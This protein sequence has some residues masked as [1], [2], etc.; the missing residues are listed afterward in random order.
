MN[1]RPR[2]HRAGAYP[3]QK[4]AMLITLSL[5]FITLTGLAA[6]AFDLGHLL[7]VRNELQNAADAAALAGANCLNKTSNSAGTD[8]TS[9]PS[10]TL[11]WSTASLRANA[12][13]ALNQSD[14]TALVNATVTT[15]YKNLAGTPAG[16]Q[17][18]TPNPV[19]LYDKPAVMVS[20]SRSGGSN[21]GAPGMLLTAMFNVAPVPIS[22][23]AVAVISSPGRVA[24]NSLIPVVIN[25]CLFDQYWDSATNSPKLAKLAN[26][27]D[28][29]GV[30]Q[31]IG[32]PWELRIGSSYHYPNCESGQWTSFDDLNVNGEI[33]LTKLIKN[34]NPT[35]LAIGD[36]IWVMPGTMAR[37]YEDLQDRH[38]TPPG[39]NVT[40]I[41]VNRPNGLA[42]KGATSIVGFAG[43][44]ITAIEGR[45]GKYI[46]G[47]FIEGAVA[48]GSSGIGPYYGTYTPPRL[49][50]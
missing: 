17:T 50:Q 6:L 31:T 35:P 19:G 48:G 49:A 33:E 2:T 28:P 45:S 25:K 1:K 4:G 12:A 38:P 26:A 37:G 22:A 29:N 15:G 9:T 41:V 7:I 36:S 40:L 44:R 18:S 16:L 20:L 46:Q 8:C 11:N 43:F 27:T 39:A 14:G 34:G 42:E 21:G 5:F 13:I 3:R 23:T 10:S 32:Q 47:H 24:P 30:P